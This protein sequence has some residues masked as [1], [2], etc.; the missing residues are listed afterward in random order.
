[1]TT[2]A[3]LS[4]RARQLYRGN[5]GLSATLQTLRPWI[6]PFEDILPLVPPGAVVMDAGCGAGL[7]L[8]LLADSGRIS[9]GLG[10]DASHAVIALAQRM[11][12]NL[13][14]GANV[15]FQQLDATAAWPQRHCD[16]ISFVDV[17]HH[18]P[19]QFQLQVLSRAIAHLPVGGLLLYKD[20]A[21]TPRWQAFC[22]RA[23]DLVLAREWI[24]YLPIAAVDRHM[25][26]HGMQELARGAA[27]RYWYAHEWRLF[28]RSR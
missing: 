23:H 20:M 21:Q 1:M 16:L 15:T 12:A 6:C 22:N 19:P 5:G 7:F 11:T 18:V 25:A 26:D 9:S 24:H 4:R 14:A 8:G 2:A 28:R 17:L 27:S 10:F 3:A 13:P